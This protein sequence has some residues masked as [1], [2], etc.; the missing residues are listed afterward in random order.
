METLI[1]LCLKELDEIEGAFVK[2]YFLTQPK[3]TLL[4]FGEEWQLS[5]REV[6]A[7]RGKAVTH[8][9]DLLAKKQ[10]HSL[11]DIL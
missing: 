11:E 5:P 2:E 9:K 6:E 3:T 1:D 10:I 4:A 8:L 7:L